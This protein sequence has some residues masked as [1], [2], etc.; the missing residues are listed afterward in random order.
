MTS[1]HYR[2][3]HPRPTPHLIHTPLLGDD[4]A[5][6][7]DHWAMIGV[8]SARLQT[9]LNTSLDKAVVPV[10]LGSCKTCD[11]YLVVAANDS[12]HIKQ[13]FTLQDGKPTSLINIFPAVNSPYGL[14]ATIQEVISCKDSQDAILRLTTPDG[15]TIYAFDQLYA[16]N[17]CHYQAGQ[18]YYVNLS[19][20]AYDID[21]SQQD[22]VVVVDDPKAIRYHRAFNDIVAKAGGDVPSDIDEQIRTWQ[23][24]SDEPLAPVEINLGHSCIYLFGETFGQ[25]DEAW[26]QAQVL[27]KSQT[28]LF[29]QAITLFDVVM[30]REMDAK[31]MVVRLATPSSAKTEVIAIHDYIQA[32]IWLQA[33]IYSSNQ[34]P[35]NG[36]SDN[37]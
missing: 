2:Y 29:D 18:D 25:Q 7:G 24:D 12:C 11:D 30:L 20:W 21:K 5:G 10:G 31:P 14:T 19:A 26:C 37:Q 6:H 28:Q 35:K 1:Q 33:A 34:S 8:D 36:Q 22:E 16:I 15:T 27:G 3:Q 9:W 23:P 4:N 32:N 17:H 13:I